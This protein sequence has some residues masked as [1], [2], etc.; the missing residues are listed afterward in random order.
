MDEAKSSQTAPIAKVSVLSQAEVGDKTDQTTVKVSESNAPELIEKKE[1]PT[2]AK[3]KTVKDS[4]EP[5]TGVTVT[6]VT[7]DFIKVMVVFMLMTIIP[8]LF[9]QVSRSKTNSRFTSQRSP[10]PSGEATLHLGRI[11]PLH[12]S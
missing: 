12:I 7:P 8:F 5:V 11:V 9:A 3:V 10:Q 1:V 4:T 6:V 2:G